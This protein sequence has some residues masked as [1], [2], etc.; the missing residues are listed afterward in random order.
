LHRGDQSLGTG[1]GARID[2][3]HPVVAHLHP[4][5]LS[6]PDDQVEVRPN[7][8]HVQL[9]ALRLL[10]PRRC[11]PQGPQYPHTER[12]GHDSVDG[13]SRCLRHVMCLTA[14]AGV[15][16]AFFAV[17]LSP[18]ADEVTKEIWFIHPT[19]RSYQLKSRYRY[20]GRLI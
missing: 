10:G 20:K 14:F 3:H 2:Q 7:L 12:G 13:R 11:H 6:V 16:S 19:T 17:T 4:D 8:D 9:P 1:L 18:T 5:V 15:L